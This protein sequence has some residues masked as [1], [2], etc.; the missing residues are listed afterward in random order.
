MAEEETQSNTFLYIFLGLCLVLLA[1]FFFLISKDSDT[2]TGGLIADIEQ[3]VPTNILETIEF[4]KL[5]DQ[6]YVTDYH[7][8]KLGEYM[9]NENF[10]NRYL[11]DIEKLRESIDAQ[12]TE[13]GNISITFLD[14][15]KAQLEGQKYFQ[16]ALKGRGKSVFYKGFRCEDKNQLLYY[17]NL[18]NQSARSAQPFFKLMDRVLRSSKEAK[19]EIGVDDNKPKFFGSPI[20]NILYVVDVNLYGIAAFCEG[21]VDQNKARFEEYLKHENITKEEFERRICLTR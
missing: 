11:N 19:N 3:P 7:E 12:N 2:P 6:K 15:R 20:G 16:M 17:T 8:E 21:K 9:I 5:L 13:E 18:Y 1:G 4:I 14:A 10:V